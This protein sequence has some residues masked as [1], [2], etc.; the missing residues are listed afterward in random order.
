MSGTDWLVVVIGLVAIAAV[1]WWFF[2]AGEDTAGDH[3]QHHHH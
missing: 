2:V 1:N 3:G